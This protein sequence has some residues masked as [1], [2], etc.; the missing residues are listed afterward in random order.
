[1]SGGIKC[2]L[3]GGQ[4]TVLYNLAGS[5]PKAGKHLDQSTV[6]A[7]EGCKAEL[8]IHI[9]DAKGTLKEL[10][11][12]SISRSGSVMVDSILR[13]PGNCRPTIPDSVNTG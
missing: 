2:L 12:S 5:G 1:M 13:L 11:S 3:M 4:H 6:A 10:L 9:W 8:A 7:A